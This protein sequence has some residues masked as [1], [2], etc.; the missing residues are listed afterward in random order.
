M[1][2]GESRFRVRYVES[3]QMGVV[4]HSNYIIWFEQGRTD[5]MREIGVD[6]ADVERD[7]IFLAVA[8]MHIRYGA[9]ARYGD[10]VRVLTRIERVQSRA[11]TFAY[12][13]LRAGDDDRLASGYTRLIAM[14]T[15]GVARRLPESL[16]ARFADVV[17][18]PAS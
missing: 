2:Q 9:P 6:Y 16:L 5:Y 10:E 12:E 3:D 15:S 11:V 18:A 17:H 4:H 7:G 1:K 14:D 8:E 13:V